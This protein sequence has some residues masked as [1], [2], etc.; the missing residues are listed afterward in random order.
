MPELF[1]KTFH[2]GWG[3]LD[4][5]GHMKNTAYLDKSVDV[6]MMYF[7]EHGFAV[8]EFEQLRL[9][10]VVKRDE[11]EYYR[12][13][14]LLE[15]MRVTLTL[16]GTSDDGTRFR[17]RNEFFREDGTLAAKITSTGG[18]LDLTARKLMVPPSGLVEALAGLVKSED[19]EPLSSSLK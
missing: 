14:R 8:R 11:I 13:L 3:D 10:P 17:K 5:N 7:Q 15:P 18:W 9:G 6:R 19:F 12:E 4:S 16:A 2:V 1:A